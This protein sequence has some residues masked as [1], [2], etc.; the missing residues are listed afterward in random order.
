M[1]L[2]LTRPDSRRMLLVSDGFVAPLFGTLSTGCRCK[3]W[4]RENPV[5]SVEELGR[6]ENHL[7]DMLVTMPSCTARWFVRYVEYVHGWK[8][9]SLLDGFNF[10][11]A[12]E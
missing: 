10:Y 5:G 1:V 4:L 7:Y 3:V 8:S 6:L 9:G 12:Y 11:V 2:A